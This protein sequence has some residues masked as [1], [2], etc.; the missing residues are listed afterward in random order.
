[1]N[2][3][4]FAGQGKPMWGERNCARC[5]LYRTL[6]ISRSWMCPKGK[7]YSPCFCSAPL[8]RYLSTSETLPPL[9]TYFIPRTAAG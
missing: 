1:M 5:S 8:P 9:K 6:F 2:Q 3:D 7:R 4:L